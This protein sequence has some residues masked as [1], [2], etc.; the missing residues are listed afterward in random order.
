MRK[1]KYHK[2]IGVLLQE[3]IY[4]KLVRVTDKQE[5]SV[6]EYVRRIIE[7]ELSKVEKGGKVDEALRS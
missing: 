7:R 4:Q 1:R 6:S 5:V 3:E 2:T